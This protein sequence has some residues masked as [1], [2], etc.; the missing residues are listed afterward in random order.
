MH[1][2]SNVKT[3]A[4]VVRSFAELDQMKEKVKGKIVVYNQ[5]WTTYG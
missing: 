1:L 4:I 3:D 5:K 2:F